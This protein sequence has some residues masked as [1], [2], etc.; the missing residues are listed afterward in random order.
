[1]GIIDTIVMEARRIDHRYP[2]MHHSNMV[3][4]IISDFGLISFRNMIL[5]ASYIV[6]INQEYSE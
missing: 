4:E 1:M 2:G 3:G 5:K 6:D